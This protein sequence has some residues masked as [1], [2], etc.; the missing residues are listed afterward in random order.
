M[1]M[2]M[3]IVDVLEHLT[4]CC[5]AFQARLEDGAVTGCEE[6]AI[7]EL[8]GIEDG[9]VVVETLNRKR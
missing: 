3:L 5:G 7:K 4:T 8:T 6:G 9:G 1:L 2:T